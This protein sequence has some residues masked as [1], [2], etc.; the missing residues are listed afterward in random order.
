MLLNVKGELREF[1]T[2]LVMG[3][4]NVTPDSFFDGGKFIEE[5]H[6]ANHIEQMVKDGA[7]VIDVG[8]VSTR[9]GAVEISM[10]EEW[11]RVEPALKL[12][13]E[14][15]KGVLVSIDTYNSA[16]AKRSVE[17]GAHIVNDIG[18][19]TFDNKMFDVVAKLKVPYILMHMQGTPATMQQNPVYKNVTTDVIDF[20]AAQITRARSAG[21][22][23]IIVDPGFGFGKT[24][25]HNYAL[26]KNLSFIKEMTGCEVLVGLSRK[27]MI[28]KV[29]GIKPEDALNGTTALNMLALNNGAKILRVHDVKE[30]KEC[31]KL[32]EILSSNNF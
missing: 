32:F 21:I 5:S 14:K 20:L 12:L 9:P 15:H 11:K 26:L 4:L 17:S 31:V 30:A 27:S 13:A 2:P 6:I 1:K 10:E 7:D 19:G 24:V 8:G 29:L 25:E 16:I 28:N 18:G 22:N 3:I 23:D